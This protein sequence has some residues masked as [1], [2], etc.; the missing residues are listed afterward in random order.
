MS[1]NTEK[2]TK[3]PCAISATKGGVKPR[4]SFQQVIL[5]WIRQILLRR[6]MHR[7]EAELRSL[8]DH[9]LQDI[10]LSRSDVTTALV[11]VRAGQSGQPPRRNKSSATTTQHPGEK[12]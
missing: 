7:A 6:A 3:T 11:E 12:L 2:A 8:D 9:M 4:K 1:I 5:R 10:G